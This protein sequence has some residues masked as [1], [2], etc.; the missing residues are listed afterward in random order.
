MEVLSNIF[1]NFN[2]K[3]LPCVS[4]K[5][6]LELGANWIHGVLGNP[7][8][9]IAIANGLIDIVH[10]PKPHRVVAATE[11]GKQVPFGVLQV[12]DQTSHGQFHSLC[13]YSFLY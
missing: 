5:H 10:V 13:F 2:P 3:K 8:Y 12:C 1:S 9:E 6:K 11:D 4:G 7:L